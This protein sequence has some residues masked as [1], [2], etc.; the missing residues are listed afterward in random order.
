MKKMIVPI[1]I[2]LIATQAIASDLVIAPPSAESSGC[3]LAR[4]GLNSKEPFLS[5]FD[6]LKTASAKKDKRSLSGMILYPMRV[7]GKVA[8]IIRTPADFSKSFDSLFTSKVQSVIERQQLNK[9]FCRDQG[10]MYGDGEI[11]VGI[12]SGK[13]GIKSLNLH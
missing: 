3:D 2:G 5:F 7:N 9:L 11:W 1:L 13:V 8:K 6:Q 10:I 12:S 4:Y